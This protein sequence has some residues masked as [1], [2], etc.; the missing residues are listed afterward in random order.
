LGPFEEE[1][2]GTGVASDV[3]NVKCYHSIIH[4]RPFIFPTTGLIKLSKKHP[5]AVVCTAEEVQLALLVSSLLIAIL[6][7]CNPTASF[8]AGAV[9]LEERNKRSAARPSRPIAAARTAGA[10]LLAL[11]VSSLLIAI[12]RHQRGF[13]ANTY[14]A[15]MFGQARHSRQEDG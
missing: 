7:V 2:E 12:L 14:L 5:I 9:T 15:R 8:A 4:F 13:L 1:E 11:F 3:V 10:L 6:T